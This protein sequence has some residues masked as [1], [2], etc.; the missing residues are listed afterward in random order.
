MSGL[1]WLNDEAWA[2]TAQPTPA[3]RR[4]STTASLAGRVGN[5][6]AVSSMRSWPRVDGL[7][8]HFD[9]GQRCERRRGRRSCELD[10]LAVSVAAG[11][12][13]SR[14][15]VPHVDFLLLDTRSARPFAFSFEAIAKSRPRQV[16]SGCKARCAEGSKKAVASGR[17]ASCRSVMKRVEPAWCFPSTREFALSTTRPFVRRPT[18]AA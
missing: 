1:F 5:S 13:V 12:F 17:T 16:A 7:G 11:R 3:R 8:R 6:G 14:R 18:P 15:V 10:R 4:R 9:N 2:A